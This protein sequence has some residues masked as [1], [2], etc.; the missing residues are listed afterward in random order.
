MR[1]CPH[2]RARSVSQKPTGRV[3]QDAHRQ[4]RHS[5]TERRH[6]VRQAQAPRVGFGEENGRA[7]KLVIEEDGRAEFDCSEEDG[8]GESGGAEIESEYLVVCSALW[9]LA[10]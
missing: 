8:M 2:H 4:G 3:E 6:S 1:E 9:R 7:T 5:K 10:A